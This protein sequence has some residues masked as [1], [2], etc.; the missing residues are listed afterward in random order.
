MVELWTSGAVDRAA[1]ARSY[2]ERRDALVG[3]LRERGVAAHG[4]SGMNVWVP[5]AD[6]TDVVT[7]LLAAGWAV[8]AG[9][10]FRVEAGPG[11]RLTVSQLSLPEVPGL[12]D[13]VAAAV[14]PGA[15]GVRYV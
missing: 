9:A 11:V 1:V 4:R 12:S 3:A 15:T 2:G 5:V 13:A 7:R 6:E 10:R 8:T 14:R